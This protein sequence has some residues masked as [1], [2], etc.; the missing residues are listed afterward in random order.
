MKSF[1]YQTIFQS[2]CRMVEASITKQLGWPIFLIVIVCSSAQKQNNSVCV[3]VCVCVCFV[4][5]LYL[6]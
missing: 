5:S 2:T 1:L 3:C 6:I 4:P